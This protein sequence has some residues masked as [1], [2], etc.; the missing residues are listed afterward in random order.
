MH[1]ANPTPYP[2]LAGLVTPGI[3]REL[4]AEH[5][6]DLAAGGAEPTAED[7]TVLTGAVRALLNAAAVFVVE[8]GGRLELESPVLSITC[9]WSS[10]ASS[11]DWYRKLRQYLLLSVGLDIA[12]GTA[13]IDGWTVTIR[14]EQS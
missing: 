2:D 9:P 14:G 12:P 6:A 4:T 7:P 8:Y 11:T 1:P 3:I 13:Q 10:D 5:L